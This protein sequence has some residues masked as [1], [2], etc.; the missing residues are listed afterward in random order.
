MSKPS[1]K[2]AHEMRTVPGLK[3]P[4]NINLHGRPVVANK[5]GSYSTEESFSRGTKDGE[6]LVPSVVKGEKL[7][8]DDAWDHYKKTGEH[9]GIF[10]TP[11]HAD[12][13]AEKVHNRTLTNS[14]G[15]KNEE[16]E[17]AIHSP[18]EDTPVPAGLKALSGK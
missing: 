11:D 9:M 16:G 1:Y 14:D 4:G 2:L 18:Q 10:D 17:A 12:S 15:T 6:V 5:D 3:T 7:S 8:Q 13:Y